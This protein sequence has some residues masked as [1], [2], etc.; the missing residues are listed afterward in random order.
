MQI[1]PHIAKYLTLVLVFVSASCSN[2]ENNSNWMPEYKQNILAADTALCKG[3]IATAL[4]K[5]EQAETHAETINQLSLID[6]IKA[7]GYYLEQSKDSSILYAHKVLDNHSDE[8]AWS[9]HE[10]YMLLGFNQFYQHP[11][12]TIYYLKLTQFELQRIGKKVSIN[13]KKD[14]CTENDRSTATHYKNVLP[15]RYYSHELDKCTG[16]QSVQNNE[17]WEEVVW[18]YLATSYSR[19]NDVN[20]AQEALAEASYYID[21]IDNPFAQNLYWYTKANN[22]I[23]ALKFDEA[24]TC[25]QKA[26]TIAHENAITDQHADSHLLLAKCLL[27][28]GE[29]GMATHHLDESIQICETIE[30]TKTVEL[31]QNEQQ[32][33]S[34][35]LQMKHDANAMHRI[36]EKYAMSDMHKKVLEAGLKFAIENGKYSNIFTILNRRDDP[37]NQNSVVSDKAKSDLICTRFSLDSTIIRHQN[38]N[39]NREFDAPQNDVSNN[40]LTATIFAIVAIS[41]ILLGSAYYFM[42]RK[43]KQI[44]DEQNAKLKR[45]LKDQMIQINLQREQMME[46]NMRIAESITYAERIQHSIL[47]HP[48]ALNQF[49]ITGS[50]IFYNPLDIVSGDFYWFI[51]QNDDLLV[52]CADCTGHGVPGA[53]MSMIASTILN[54]ICEKSKEIMPSQ[55]LEALDVRII[56]MVGHNANEDGMHDG[57]DISVAKI[58]LVTKKVTLSAARRPIFIMRDQE[59][60]EYYGTRRSIGDTESEFRQR[61]FEDT[62]YQLHTGDMLYMFTD[63]YS[64]QFGGINGEK[65]KNGKIKKLIR[66]MHDD[67]MDDQSLTIQELFVQWK[68]DYPQTDDVLFMGIKI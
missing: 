27:V 5:S 51:K 36:I 63:G 25:A 62:E 45:A 3:D 29:L 6:Y 8:L 33:V 7:W 60:V 58:N 1:I 35:L 55:L 11:D 24:N 39:K 19:L 49:D 22:N 48:E 16:T 40:T 12:S 52:C 26:A 47:P 56:N 38:D 23:L 44:D 32:L 66:S 67:D 64:D 18:L 54:D 31:L 4:I 9:R 28:K 17:V 13:N 41:F 34:D 2:D 42:K 15:M 61:Q 46:T 68:G 10:M 57:L 30:H 65:L 59:F 50:F 43:L 53:F 20:R 21:L 14:I 37:F